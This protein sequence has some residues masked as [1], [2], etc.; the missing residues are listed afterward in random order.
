IFADYP[1]G[2]HE[3]PFN[4]NA[5]GIYFAYLTNREC[6]LSYLSEQLDDFGYIN[7]N[8]YHAMPMGYTNL[9]VLERIFVVNSEGVWKIFKNEENT[10]ILFCIEDN[11]QYK[12][13]SQSELL[14]IVHSNF[15]NQN[16]SIKE[17]LS[18]WCIL[19]KNAK[20]KLQCTK[21]SAVGTILL[22]NYYWH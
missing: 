15:E 2:I 12:L 10:H 1:T 3:N 7:K 5:K 18:N 14:E 21:I 9:W 20:E 4:I 22:E 6:C 16:S 13:I 17:E 19:L 8:L 11:G